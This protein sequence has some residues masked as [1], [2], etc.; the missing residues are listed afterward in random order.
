MPIGD[1]AG[2][3]PAVKR[4]RKA[5]GKLQPSKVGNAGGLRTVPVGKKTNP[6]RSFQPVGKTPPN[7][8][9]RQGSL[10]TAKRSTPGDMDK[11][12]AAFGNKLKLKQRKLY[13]A[14]KRRT[15]V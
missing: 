1:P 15:N 11:L 2:Y 13:R 10:S 3:L 6:T 7:M 9:V 5:R 4:K 14:K 8:A 12:K